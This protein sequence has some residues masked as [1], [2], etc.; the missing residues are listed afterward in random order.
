MKT[1][2]DRAAQW[3]RR[4]HI[5][6]QFLKNKVV[7]RPGL[8]KSA[9]L[10]RIIKKSPEFFPGVPYIVVAR[11]A[12]QESIIP[13]TNYYHQ[14]WIHIIPIGRTEPRMEIYL[15]RLRWSQEPLPAFRG[16]L[17]HF[18][19]R[20]FLGRIKHRLDQSIEMLAHRTSGGFGIAR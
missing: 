16:T 18:R 17:L 6:F 12:Y 9:V 8:K 2:R 10:H 15:I 4:P 5:Q 7:R 20:L 19:H 13:S 11:P 3:L 14:I 1:M